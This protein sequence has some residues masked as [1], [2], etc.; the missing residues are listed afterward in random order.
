VYYVATLPDFRR[1]G[2]GE[3][4]T[5]RAIAQG[6]AA[7]CNVATLQAS[8]LGLPIYERMGFRRVGYYRTYVEQEA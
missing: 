7:G 8:P 5:R 4:M 3:A 6:A 2:L 1:R